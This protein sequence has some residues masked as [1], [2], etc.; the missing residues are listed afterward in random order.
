VRIGLDILRFAWPGSPATIGPTLG[1]IARDAELAGLDSLWMMDHLFQIGGFGKAEDEML[2]VYAALAFVAGQTERIRLGSL[3]TAV[4][5]RH[6]GVL[7]KQVTTLDVL[8]GGRA[9]LGIGAG[10]YEEEQRG[11][12]IPTYPLA[13]RFE[14]LEETLRIAH[15][16]WASDES[17]FEGKHYRL[18]R[19]LN[20]P[21]SLQRPHPPILLGGAGE[22]KTL[23]MVARYAD[24]CNFLDGIGHE[25]LR[26]KLGVLARHCDMIGRPYTEIEKTVFTSLAA[27]GGLVPAAEIVDRANRFAEL[28][29][30]HLIVD[31]PDAWRDG[32]LDVLAEVAPDVHAITPTGR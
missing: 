5:Y 15:Q 32:S 17:P 23:P 21:N 18:E 20:V 29:F 22:R 24:A 13:E 28:G 14:R 12:G 26:H 27:N 19:P 10:W 9:Y 4:T 2:E 25:Q 11:L 3:V 16:M 30:D 6:P 7:M 1:R 31:T 8:S